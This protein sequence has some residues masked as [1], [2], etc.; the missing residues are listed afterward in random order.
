LKI[1]VIS[2][3]LVFKYF[4]ELRKPIVEDRIFR[5]EGFL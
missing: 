4:Q 5:R 3:F 1:Y 2:D